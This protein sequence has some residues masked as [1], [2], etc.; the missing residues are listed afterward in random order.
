MTMIPRL[1]TALRRLPVWAVWVL[2]LIPLALLIWDTVAGNLGVEPIRDIE[3]RLGLTALYFLI[4][5]LTISPLLR[6]L[7]LNLMRYRQAIG[8]L[9]FTYIC[10]HV[11]SWA[12]MDMGF[13]WRQ[14]GM[15]ILKRPYLTLGMLAFACLIPLAVTSNRFSIRK[16][17]TAG[18]RRL[19]QLVYPAVA[20]ACLHYLWVGKIIMFGPALWLAVTVALLIIRPLLL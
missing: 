10:L 5:G 17:G 15:D 8:L 6:L 2:G 12:V 1:N 11:L 3:H 9:A 18:W 19:H 4:G 7:R 13:L 14:M 16:M 20:L